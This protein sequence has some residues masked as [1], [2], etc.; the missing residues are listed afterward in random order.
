MLLIA[1]KFIVDDFQTVAAMFGMGGAPESR[2]THFLML[3][4]A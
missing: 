3:V 2:K 4:G 1:K